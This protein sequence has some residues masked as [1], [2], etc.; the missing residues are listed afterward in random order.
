[1]LIVSKF[2]SVYKSIP[3]KTQLLDIQNKSENMLQIISVSIKLAD[4][5]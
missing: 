5:F 4:K 2:L 1:M 3:S